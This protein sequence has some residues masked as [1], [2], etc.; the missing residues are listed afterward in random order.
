M[1]LDEIWRSARAIHHAHP[2]LSSWV[3]GVGSLLAV[4]VAA[5]VFLFQDFSRRR[6]RREDREVRLVRES[7]FASAAAE[8]R[9][10]KVEGLLISAWPLMVQ[11]RNQMAEVLK[12]LR[13]SIA[14]PPAF[15]AD[16][17][18]YE[19]YVIGVPDEWAKIESDLQC[20]GAKIAVP[21][22]EMLAILRQFDRDIAKLE[23]RKQNVNYAMQSE[24][25]VGAKRHADEAIQ[26]LSI[27]Y[28]DKLGR[29]PKRSPYWARNAA[30]EV[31][32]ARTMGRSL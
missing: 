4:I 2:S 11:T 19:D 21:I 3:Q 27:L 28:F 12:A 20:L 10:I 24:F 14:K 22:Y 31:K 25:L 17:D 23:R 30:A 13:M 29:E 32:R 6:E 8:D 26:T 9:R 15:R 16:H 1:S 5:G 7:A 18:Y